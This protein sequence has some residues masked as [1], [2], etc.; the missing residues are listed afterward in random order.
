M[1]FAKK[2]QA[3]MDVPF[4][5]DAVGDFV[6]ESVEVQDEWGAAEDGYV[7]GVRMVLRGPGGK[8][9]ALRALKPL[10]SQHPTTFS[11]YGNPYQLWFRKPEIESLGDQRYAVCVKGAGM[12]VHLEPEL[13]RFLSHLADANQLATPP[14][15]ATQ[16]AL[17]AAYLEQ[18]RAEIKSL[19]DRYRRKVAKTENVKEKYAD[20]GDDP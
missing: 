7:Y 4:P 2:F 14:D 8:Q 10:F 16:E 1:P 12:R 20:Q 9:A 13:A 15:P 6:V 18:Y 3:M 19:V 17:V 5:G 11:G